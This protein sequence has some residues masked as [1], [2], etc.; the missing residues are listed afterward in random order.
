MNQKL[1][2]SKATTII[3]GIMFLIMGAVAFL[4]KLNMVCSILLVII[5]IIGIVGGLIGKFEEKEKTGS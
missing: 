2:I 5:G 1:A 4:C 3:M